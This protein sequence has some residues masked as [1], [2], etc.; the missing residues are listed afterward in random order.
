MEDRS[1]V[2]KRSVVQKKECRALNCDDAAVMEL[3]TD[4]IPV[5]SSHYNQVINLGRAVLFKAKRQNGKKA[6]FH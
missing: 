5:C 2:E 4:N 6:K 3:G 1:G